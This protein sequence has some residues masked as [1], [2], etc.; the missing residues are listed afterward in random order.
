VGAGRG[1]IDV[2]HALAAHLGLRNFNTA[3]FADDAAMFQALVL[4]AQALVVLD[5]TED[6]GAEQTVTLGLECAVVDGFGLF[7][8]PEGP[9]TDLLRR[10]H[11]DP[12]GI[13]MLIGRELLEQV[14]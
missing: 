7:D 14:E 5:R 12:D 10:G 3:L 11:A 8:F 4:A 6:L 13:E 2:T 9:R 1:Q